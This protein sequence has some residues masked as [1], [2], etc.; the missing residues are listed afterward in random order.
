[1]NGSLDLVQ[2]L[3]NAGARYSLTEKFPLINAEKRGSE[4]VDML[5]N[6]NS[7]DI[8]AHNPTTGETVLM[9]AAKYCKNDNTMIQ[10]IQHGADI[11]AKDEYGYTLLMLAARDKHYKPNMNTIPRLIAHGANVNANNYITGNGFT[12]LMEATQIGNIAAFDQL[13]AGK[14]AI[15]DRRDQQGNTCLMIAC[16]HDITKYSREICTIIVD[17]LIA[18][19]ADVNGRNKNGRTP[20]MFAATHGN[21]YLMEKLILS[22]ANINET[23]NKGFTPLMLACLEN[24]YKYQVQTVEML[25]K[26]NADIKVINKDGKN[27]MFYAERSEAPIAT[28][29]KKANAEKD[30]LSRVFATDGKRRRDQQKKRI[31]RETPL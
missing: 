29:L 7:D 18:A 27:A 2:L 17:K 13:I 20:L 3:I 9:I 19:N 25:I 11:N 28:I 1:M 15:I 23:D 22:K 31:R 14:D 4:F 21:Y 16:A 30:A 12:A 6:N 8:N 24:R 10:L 26:C 5:I